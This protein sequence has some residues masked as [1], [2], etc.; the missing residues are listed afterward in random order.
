MKFLKS[1]VLLALLGTV[2]GIASCKKDRTTTDTGSGENITATFFGRIIDENGAPVQNATVKAGSITFNTDRN[3][4]FKLKNAMVDKRNAF[5]TATKTGFFDGSR[6]IRANSSSSNYI[7]IMLIRKTLSGSFSSSAGSTIN[8]GTTASVTFAPNSIKKTDGTAYS[9]TVKVYATHL[10]PSDANLYDKMPGNLIG[11]RTNNNETMMRTFGMLNVVLEDASG[12]KLNIADG[13]TA[14]ISMYVPSSLLSSAT[15]SIV[16]WHF[17]E[18]KGLW[19]E[20]G[21]ATLMGNKYVGTVSHFSWWNCDTPEA[22]INLCLRLVDQNGNAI[23][24]AHTILTNLSNNDSRWGLADEDG[25]TCGLV[26]SNT[27]LRLEYMDPCD[28]NVFIQNIGPFTSDTDL[29]N[30]TV[31]LNLSQT[32]YFTGQL[33]NCSGTPVSNGYVIYNYDGNDLV[34]E[35]DA[36]GN[37][38]FSFQNCGSVNNISVTGVDLTAFEQSL[39]QNVAFASGNVTIPTF[40]ACGTAI[41]EYI[42]YQIDGGNVVTS[43]YPSTYCD[44]STGLPQQIF[45][46]IRDSLQANGSLYISFMGTSPYPVQNIYYTNNSTNIYSQ[47]GVAVG[48]NTNLTSYATAVNEYFEGTI[49]GTY[50]ATQNS[51]GSTVTGPHS[52]SCTFRLKRRN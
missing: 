42:T 1:I 34:A 50:T 40:N 17:D 13:Q 38:S 33:L 29:G 27:T 20:E 3:G 47:Q 12:N 18:E 41:D 46:G 48:L 4:V 52:I 37:Y 8:V 26:Y 10:N 2:L 25:R 36:N 44:V 49:S 9:G 22:A 11:T 51:G 6:T 14:T 15:S 23:S 45:I 19:R 35:T 21:S 7:Q 30:I 16:L 24:Y 32:G 31:T 28:N 43:V 39:P 5:I